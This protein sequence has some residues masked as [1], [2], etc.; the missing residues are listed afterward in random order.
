MK[1]SK[2]CPKCNGQN[3]Y[4]N[5]G[6]TSR[7]ERSFVIVSSWTKLFV[8]NYVCMD[9]GFFEEYVTPEDLRNVAKQE[10]VKSTWKK[11]DFNSK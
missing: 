9:C 7:G 11:V 8:E 6:L 2:V 1:D 4:T 3:I 10:K 5:S